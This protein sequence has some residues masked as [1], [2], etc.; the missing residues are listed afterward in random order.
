MEVFISREGLSL[1]V[2]VCTCMVSKQ[3]KQARMSTSVNCSLLIF[4]KKES[5]KQMPAHGR[6]LILPACVCVSVC[7]C[8]RMC[9][10]VSSALRPLL[11]K[12]TYLKR[13]AIGYYQER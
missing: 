9:V 11:S 5:A 10:C 13:A 4:K 6:L 3:G 2:Y 8:V 7:E 1:F 12:R